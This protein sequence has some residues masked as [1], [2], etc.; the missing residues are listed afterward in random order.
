MLRPYDYEP[1]FK[2]SYLKCYNKPYTYKL[3][4]LKTILKRSY[5]QII[6][7]TRSMNCARRVSDFLS[8]RCVIHVL[9]D[10]QKLPEPN[11]TFREGFAAGQRLIISSHRNATL[12]FEN[13]DVT[14]NYFRK[15]V[16]ETDLYFVFKKK[17][18][19][20]I[21]FFDAPRTSIIYKH[22]VSIYGVYRAITFL[23]NEN[24]YSILRRAVDN[25]SSY[26]L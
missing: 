26:S 24:Q 11:Y 9:V 7:L 20:L 4:L 21:L 16:L 17:D 10:D 23:S 22:H 2:H 5:K 19:N 14:Q 3:E 6:V 18:T 8:D 13:I 1:Q 25:I 12:R 15:K